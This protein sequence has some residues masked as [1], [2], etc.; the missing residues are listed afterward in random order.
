[1]ATIK[2][3]ILGG[4]AGKVGNVTGSSWKGISVM[5]KRPDSV[6]NPRTA[7]QV[8]NRNA[9]KACSQFAS[10]ILATMIIPLMNRF[11]KQMSGYNLFI[12]KNKEY[13]NED[14]IQTPE[15]I[16]FGTGKLGATDI[17]TAVV[18][19]GTGNATIT[20]NGALNNQYKQNSDKAY[21][22]V[23]D[24]VTKEI[25][26]Q[27]NDEGLVER[28]DESW[29]IGLSETPILGRVYWIYLTFL[30]EDGTVVGNTAYISD[31][32]TA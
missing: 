18:S 20:W 21:A 16:N 29:D 9:F 11:A 8:S 25:L 26:F 31:A 27:G 17:D 5:K 19:V 3:G 6:A 13:F 28:E 2:S 7:G 12:Q 1:M 22:M 24:S 4:F 23:V 14:G 10:L 15:S 30:R 32:A